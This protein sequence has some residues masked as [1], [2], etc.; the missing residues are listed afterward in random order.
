MTGLE[1]TL[2]YIYNIL[3]TILILFMAEK[4]NIN[5]SLIKTLT[6]IFIFAVVGLGLSMISRNI[7]YILGHL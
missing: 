2:Q 5:D 6:K 7:Q 4:P 1:A 3:S